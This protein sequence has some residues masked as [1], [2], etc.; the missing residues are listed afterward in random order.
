MRLPG[1]SKRSAARQRA[2]WKRL[3]RE[4]PRHVI[5]DAELNEST[6]RLNRHNEAVYLESSGQIPTTFPDDAS[7]YDEFHARKRLPQKK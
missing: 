2:G 3:V 6:P 7:M 1:L 4:Q 5:R